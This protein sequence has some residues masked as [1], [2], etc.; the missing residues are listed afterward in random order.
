M[1]HPANMND[2]RYPHQR[3]TGFSPVCV[4]NSSHTIPA[5]NNNHSKEILKDTLVSLKHGT[6]FAKFKSGKKKKNCPVFPVIFNFHVSKVSHNPHGAY[7][8]CFVAVL[9]ELPLEICAA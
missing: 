5:P 1:R 8:T 3:H 6:Y 7:C 4:D 9:H 2:D